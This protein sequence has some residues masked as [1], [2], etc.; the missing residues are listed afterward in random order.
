MSDTLI[1]KDGRKYPRSLEQSHEWIDNLRDQLQRERLYI[2]KLE[3]DVGQLREAIDTVLAQGG[4]AKTTMR[5]ILR[6]AAVGCHFGL[7][8]PYELLPMPEWRVQQVDDW[9][10]RQK[11]WIR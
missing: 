9:S 6:L 8:R 11:G 3:H 1:E 10:L 2:S 7:H 4:L 5:R